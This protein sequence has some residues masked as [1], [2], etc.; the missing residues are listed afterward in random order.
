M[1]PNDDEHLCYSTVN[2]DLLTLIGINLRNLDYRYITGLFASL[3]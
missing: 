3:W 2:I 1:N